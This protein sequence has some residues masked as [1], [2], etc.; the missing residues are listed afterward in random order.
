MGGRRDVRAGVGTRARLSPKCPNPEPS[1]Q[2][3]N[4]FP[5]VLRGL[6]TG[7]KLGRG[8]RMRTGTRVGRQGLLS[9]R[10]T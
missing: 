1:T 8:T 9:V 3:N 5:L 10:V 4:E 6:A 2:E 7:P